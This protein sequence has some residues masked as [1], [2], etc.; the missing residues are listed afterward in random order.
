MLIPYIPKQYV[1]WECTSIKESQI[2]KVLRKHGFK[3]ITSHINED[4][5]FLNY[6]PKEHYD[7][8][9]RKPLPLH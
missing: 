8:F 4:E 2:V 3:V 1:I 9:K 7:N 6:E 5:N